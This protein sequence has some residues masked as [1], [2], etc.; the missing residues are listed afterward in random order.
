MSVAGSH[1]AAAEADT[2]G[3]VRRIVLRG[4]ADEPRAALLT[5]EW[6]VTNGLGGYAA[7]TIGGAPSR[8]YHGL[9]I[10]ALAPPY[11]RRLLLTDV[12]EELYF[13]GRRVAQL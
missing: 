5:R 1:V 12:S 6:L 9:L 10:A 8:R 13:D 11:G 3:P 4:L 7:G 2:S